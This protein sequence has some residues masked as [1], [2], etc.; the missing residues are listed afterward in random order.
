MVD[1]FSHTRPGRPWLAYEWLSEVGMA[2]G[3]H[4]FD[5]RGLIALTAAAAAL[6]FGLFARALMRFMA[7]PAALVIT[8]LS[9][10][11]VTP[12]LTARPHALAM[13]FFVAW[14]SALVTA[15]ARGRAPSFWLL[16]IM[17]VW[18][19]MHGAFVIG[20]ALA[21]AMGAEAIFLAAPDTR[22]S[23]ARRWLGFLAAAMC[24]SLITPTASNSGFSPFT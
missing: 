12:H 11:L 6:A 22:P 10:L 17:V 14:V 21:A 19:N 23:Q 15:R 7:P 8:A 4:A 18:A 3:F 2:L 20:L 16:P 24:A 13:P 1:V 5:W 9:F